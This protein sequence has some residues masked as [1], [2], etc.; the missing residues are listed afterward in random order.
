LIVAQ[1]FTAGQIGKIIDHQVPEGRLM[2]SDKTSS[3]VPTGLG[4]I[5]V[6]RLPSSELLG[7]YR[8]SLRDERSGI[9]TD[10]SVENP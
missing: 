7:Y 4:T 3:I 1:Q 2:A 6:A 10:S 9:P 8:A 5:G